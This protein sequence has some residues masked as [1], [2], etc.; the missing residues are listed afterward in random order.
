M[1]QLAMRLAR[2]FDVDMAVADEL[3]R[4]KLDTP[5]KVRRATDQ[6]LRDVPKIGQA[7]LNLIRARKS[8]VESK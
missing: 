2:V 5:A 8:K 7:T 4:C 1:N 6:E 3:V